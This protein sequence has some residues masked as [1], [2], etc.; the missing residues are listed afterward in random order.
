MGLESVDGAA[1]VFWTWE[2]GVV[3]T[4]AVVALLG[5]GWLS[6]RYLRAA[7]DFPHKREA[8]W[9]ARWFGPWA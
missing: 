3:G 1:S 4:L 9:G 7:P 5:S 8:V 6:L 2:V